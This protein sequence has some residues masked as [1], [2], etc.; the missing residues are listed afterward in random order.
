M[1]SKK[2]S[3][4]KNSVPILFYGAISGREG[5]CLLVLGVSH[6]KHKKSLLNL[7]KNDTII[8]E[9]CDNSARLSRVPDG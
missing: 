6:K 5:E 8:N 2:E 3:V 9:V 7:V 1:I 4:R